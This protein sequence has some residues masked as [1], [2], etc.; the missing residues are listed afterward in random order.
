[1]HSWLTRKNQLRPNLSPPLCFHRLNRLMQ[2]VPSVPRSMLTPNRSS[3][4]SYGDSFCQLLLDSN[5]A[6]FVASSNKCFAKLLLVVIRSHDLLEESIC[7]ESGRKSAS[8]DLLFHHVLPSCTGHFC[9]ATFCQP[10]GVS[11]FTELHRV[12]LAIAYHQNGCNRAQ[13][14]THILQ[15]LVVIYLHVLARHVLLPLSRFFP[16]HCFPLFLGC[17]SVPHGTLV[18]QRALTVD[19]NRRLDKRND[20]CS[21]VLGPGCRLPSDAT[22]SRRLSSSFVPS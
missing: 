18:S 5:C 12:R 10:E 1:M 22:S 7:S 9:F 15:A 3:S 2:K 21:G 11:V 16:Y 14:K 6:A 4:F 8:R 20:P 17:F 13:E 19:A